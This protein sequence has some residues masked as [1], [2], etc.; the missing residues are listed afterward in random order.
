MQWAMVLSQPFLV[1][2][3]LLANMLDVFENDTFS[4]GSSALEHDEGHDR[5][6][7]GAFPTLRTKS[8]SST[9]SSSTSSFKF[10]LK[11]QKADKFHGFEKRTLNK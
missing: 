4:C 1:P 5:S 9:K 7:E 6:S 3:T 11:G 8:S 2:D 10:A